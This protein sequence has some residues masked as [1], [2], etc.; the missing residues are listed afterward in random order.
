M[1]HF[2]LFKEYL[3][4]FVCFHFF[5]LNGFGAAFFLQV[6][7]DSYKKKT[8]QL[9]LSQ[10][11]LLKFHCTGQRAFGFC[12]KQL[13]SQCNLL[14][15]VCDDSHLGQVYQNKGNGFGENKVLKS[16][17]I[18]FFLYTTLRENVVFVFS[19]LL[20]SRLGSQRVLQGTLNFSALVAEKGVAE[21]LNSI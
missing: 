21:T 2:C 15:F 10:I 5:P 13:F 6:E 9:N 11:S 20:T 3:R 18:F 12:Q 17:S 1:W 8:Q 16:N 14:Y 4:D 7:L 19:H